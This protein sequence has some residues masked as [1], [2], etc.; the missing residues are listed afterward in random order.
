M[1]ELHASEPGSDERVARAQR[2]ADHER[3]AAAR[4]H[5]AADRERD[6]GDRARRRAGDDPGPA[7]QGLTA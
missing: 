3:E 7:W 1:Q 2:L 6:R 5:D 4:E